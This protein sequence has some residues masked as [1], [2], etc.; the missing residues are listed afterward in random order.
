MKA[1]HQGGAARG[2]RTGRIRGW[3]TEPNPAPKG[4][5]LRR[6]AARLRQSARPA[7]LLAA[8]WLAF[9]AQAPA[10]GAEPQAAQESEA[11]SA[12][13][14]EALVGP[15]ALY[16]DDLLAV[17][18]PAS[19]YPLQ[20]VQAARFLKKQGK[21]RAAKPDEGWNEA[22]IALLN[23]P[24]A[25]QLLN[26]DLD[27]TW[28]LGEA[29]L[30]QEEDVIA[31]ISAF[32]NRA[33]LA[34]N[35]KSDGKQQV[36]V[37]D[38]A[39]RI[40]S[41]NPAS[42]HVPYYEPAEVIVRHQ[43]R[44][45]YHYYPRAYPV[46]YYPYDRRHR[47]HDDLFWGVTSAFSV[48]WSTGRLHWHHYGFHDHP[49]F[50]YRYYDPF[51]YRRPHLHLS[52]REREHRRDRR[53]RRH[54]R[55]HD[56]TRWRPRGHRQGARPEHPHRRGSWAARQ[57][58]L[59]YAVTRHSQRANDSERGERRADRQRFVRNPDRAN[60]PAPRI[61]API[62]TGTLPREAARRPRPSGQGAATNAGQAPQRWDRNAPARFVR[63][64]PAERPP[65]QAP[66]QAHQAA[67]RPAAPPAPVAPVRQRPSAPNRPPAPAAAPSRGW[68]PGAINAIP[69]PQRPV[70]PAPRPGPARQ[71]KPQTGAFSPEALRKQMQRP[72]P[73]AQAKRT[74]KDIDHQ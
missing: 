3:R 61:H 12:E 33:R 2:R 28:R 49:Y 47:F 18:L 65:R 46:Y 53:H 10:A 66:R 40:R 63:P 21:R 37:E 60:R 29:V 31:A 27:W 72:P 4:R 17:V 71:A 26:E 52:L 11:L 43:P 6:L 69:R 56:G 62:Q 25:L 22:V 44:R 14:L 8:F 51:Y 73:P 13:E 16:P 30:A 39:I 20:V 24:E 42:I 15:V 41:T 58:E 45:V 9:A 7:A 23:Y 1:L 36:A 55:H 59:G 70:Q 64:T 68:T 74:R 57:E 34:G 19:T 67:R 50:G 48:G 38:D 54:E 5:R 32:R 35:L